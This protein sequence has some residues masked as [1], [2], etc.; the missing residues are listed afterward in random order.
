MSNDTIPDERA[1]SWKVL[2]PVSEDKK[3]LAL[4]LSRDDI[5]GLC[6]SY[7]CVDNEPRKYKYEIIVIGNKKK[8]KF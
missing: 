5:A 1:V 6:R 7:N 4:G 8:I 2:L 3:I